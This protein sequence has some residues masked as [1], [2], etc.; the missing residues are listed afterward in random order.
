MAS[1]TTT[2]VLDNDNSV[3]DP[4][5]HSDLLEITSQTISASGGSNATSSSS[6]SPESLDLERFFAG[7]SHEKSDFILQV[8]FGVMMGLCFSIIISWYRY[9]RDILRFTG[10]NQGSAS[11]SLPV[12]STERMFQSTVILNNN[13]AEGNRIT[14][15]VYQTERVDPTRIESTMYNPTGKGTVGGQGG[16]GLGMGGLGGLGMGA[17]PVG[18]GVIPG[19]LDHSA[20]VSAA[21]TPGAASS[22]AGVNPLLN[23]LLQPLNTLQPG[24]LQEHEGLQGRETQQTDKGSPPSHLAIPGL[25]AAQNG[26]K[27][28]SSLPPSITPTPKHEQANEFF[29]SPSDLSPPPTTMS[30]NHLQQTSSGL[31]GGPGTS[32]VT[33]NG[34]STVVS[35]SSAGTGAETKKSA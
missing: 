16:G 5:F 23:P 6:S 35:T 28:D 30:G 7:F 14:G 1:E 20:T 26:F 15:Q 17:M 25:T 13:L 19:P 22:S 31:N 3:L 10:R 4:D 32:A 9:R 29:E 18:P 11:T 34:R 8:N 33:V 27:E 21:S 12:L 24:Q 2:W